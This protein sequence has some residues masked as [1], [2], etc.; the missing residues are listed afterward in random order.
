MIVRLKAVTLFFLLGAVFAT[1]TG[2]SGASSSAMQETYPATGIGPATLELHNLSHEQILF[3]FMSPVSQE[4]WGSDL[5][6]ADVLQV[7]QSFIITSIETGEWD[8][9]VV[10]SSGNHKEFREQD[11][12]AGGGYRLEVTHTD[13]IH[14]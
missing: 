10:D 12:D 4:Y 8:I 11:F 14:D 2:C 1:A 5:L 3:V 9:R 6:G 7:G 13:W